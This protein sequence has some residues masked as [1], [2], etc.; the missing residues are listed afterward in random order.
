MVHIDS[1]DAYGTTALHEACN[2]GK[3]GM[4]RLLLQEGANVNL[5]SGVDETPLMIT[6]IPDERKGRGKLERDRHLIL[7]M[8]V[9][10][11][12]GATCKDNR[13]KSA[14]SKSLK[15]RGYSSKEIARM[16]SPD[17]LISSPAELAGDI[18][19][20]P[21]VYEL[22][23]VPRFTPSSN[24]NIPV[25]SSWLGFQLAELDAPMSGATVAETFVVWK[26]KTVGRRLRAL[27]D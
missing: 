23:T 14:V 24:S 20:R 25:Q 27:G 22:D 16:L 15:I 1:A 10:H 8:L 5:A 17:P 18:P 3:V 11:G 7:K 6:C 12:A 4:V 21:C 19:T 26:M 9:N 13:G 2:K